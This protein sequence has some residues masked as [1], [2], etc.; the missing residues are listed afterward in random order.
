MELKDQATVTSDDDSLALQVTYENNGIAYKIDIGDGVYTITSTQP[1]AH[2]SGVA[3]VLAPKEAKRRDVLAAFAK[4]WA[5]HTIL[6]EAVFAQYTYSEATDT[7]EADYIL[8][9]FESDNGGSLILM[10]REGEIVSSFE[11]EGPQHL[12]GSVE[13]DFRDN[14]LTGDIT[15]AAP[16]TVI[17]Y[18]T[19]KYG[20]LVTEQEHWDKTC[21]G[22][23][24]A[25]VQHV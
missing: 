1:E 22:E 2:L 13:A 16:A 9:D 12:L 25:E 24:D 3:K 14:K 11:L 17:S 10:H 19:N 7:C 21:P 15:N 6:G 8:F 4:L 20:Y 23:A 18:F 5:V